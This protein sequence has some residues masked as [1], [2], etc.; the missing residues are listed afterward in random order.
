LRPGLP[1]IAVLVIVTNILPEQTV[2][3]LATLWTFG[4]PNQSGTGRN[5]VRF[6]SDN[7]VAQCSRILD[8]DSEPRVIDYDRTL[9]YRCTD[10][11]AITMPEVLL[12]SML[13][14]SIGGWGDGFGISAEDALL[15]SILFGLCTVVAALPGGMLWVIK[16]S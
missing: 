14:I 5:R 16:A 1:G 3:L 11:K 4:T 8:V 9:V 10:C 13:P 15:S 6:G 12:V 7:A 2:C